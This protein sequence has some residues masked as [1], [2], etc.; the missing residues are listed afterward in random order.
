MMLKLFTQMMIS[1]G[2]RDGFGIH[3]YEYYQKAYDLFSPGGNCVLMTARHNGIDLAAVMIFKFGK[4]CWYFYGASTEIERN[5]MPVY[6]LQWQ[7][8]SVG[9]TTGL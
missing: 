6:L 5:R 3:S 7:C 9:K 4:R 1:T 2:A 8:H